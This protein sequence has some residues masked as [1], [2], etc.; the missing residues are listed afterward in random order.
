MS[1][2]FVAL[3]YVAWSSVFSLGKLALEHS[4]PLFLTAFR[5]LFAAVLI[6]SFL[7]I[8]KRSSLKLSL[9]QFAS[10]LLLAFF[11]IYLTNTLEFWG[12]QYL[13][14]AKTCFIYSLSPFF[15][16]LFS[17]IHFNEKMNPRKWIGLSIGF[18]GFIPVLLTQTGS[19]ELLNAFSFF[20][21]P[22]LAIIG[23]ALSSVYGWVLLRLMVK[24]QE[25]TPLVANG[26]SMLFGGLFALIHSYLI[27]PGAPFPIS[28]LHLTSFIKRVMLITV[29]SNLICYN[30]YGMFL[31]KYTATFMSFVGLLSPIFASLNA[32]LFLGETPSWIIVVS[33]SIVSTG[34][35][36]VYRV[37]LKQ[38]YVVS[39]K[40]PVSN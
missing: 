2:F 19:E 29:I 39:S 26:T 35:W 7:L 25:I 40:T 30:L 38:G 23:A 33:T 10:V 20:S 3:M 24:E 27:E 22:T 8:T 5:M 37:E 6:L 21:W 28:P 18:I 13:S 11:S 36:I 14:A 12:L 4:P 34:L 17:Y 1:V 31:K 32:W 15:A 16:A 9:K